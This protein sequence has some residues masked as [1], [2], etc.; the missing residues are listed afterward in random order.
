LCSSFPLTGKKRSA[1]FRNFPK[2]I[3]V[4]EEDT[5]EGDGN[6]DCR[7]EKTALIGLLPRLD[8]ARIRM[9]SSSTTC[10]LISKAEVLASD[11][12]LLTFAQPASKFV[13]MNELVNPVCRRTAL[14]NRSREAR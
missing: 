7:F 5:G 4:R 12:N 2:L 1:F 9:G 10:I 6:T 3:P 14:A 13:H 11:K 8:A